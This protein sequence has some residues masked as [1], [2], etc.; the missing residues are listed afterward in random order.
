MTLPDVTEVK[1]C[2]FDMFTDCSQGKCTGQY[3]VQ[4]A[5]TNSHSVCLTQPENM[6]V[7]KGHFICRLVMHL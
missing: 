7:P 5:K 4:N 1:N 2:M 3:T 6:P